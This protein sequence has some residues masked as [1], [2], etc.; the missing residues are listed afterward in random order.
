MKVT[1]A[2]FLR[3]TAI[4][5]LAAGVLAAVAAAVAMQILGRWEQSLGFPL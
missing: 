3:N 4:G 1:R 5:L 2:S